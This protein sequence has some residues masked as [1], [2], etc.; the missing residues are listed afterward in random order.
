MT[1]SQ[2]HPADAAGSNPQPSDQAD[3][4]DANPVDLASVLAGLTRILA[5]PD[6]RLSQTRDRLLELGCDRL[7]FHAGAIAKVS[8]STC[9]IRA[10]WPTPS[11]PSAPADTPTRL[12]Q[13][14]A[15]SQ[16]FCQRTIDAGQTTAIQNAADTEDKTHPA[17]QELGIAAYLGTPITINGRVW[18]TLSFTRQAPLSRAISPNDH[19]VIELIAATLGAEMDRDYLQA[20]Y[21]TALEEADLA[22]RETQIVLD[23]L[24]AMVWR[25]DKTNTIFQTNK[26]AAYAVGA[27]P[28]QMIGRPIT[29]FYPEHAEASH[30]EDLEVIRSG[31]PLL[32][33]IESWADDTG[34]TRFVQ[35]DRIP[36]RNPT[37]GAIDGILVVSND[38]T[39]LKRAEDELRSMNVRFQAFTRNSP[40]I[41]WA[42]DREGRYVF[43]N[44]AFAEMMQVE[45]EDCVGK[46]PTDVLEPRTAKAFEKIMNRSAVLEP[47][48]AD[49][50]SSD[51]TALEQDSQTIHADLP[52]DHRVVPLMV[53]RFTYT[54]AQGRVFFGGT[55]MDLTDV[56]AAQRELATRNK[57]LKALL[58]VISHDL[59]EPLRAIR[60]F[61]GLVVER[62]AAQLGESSQD[63]L[64]RVV[65]GAERLDQL[66]SDVLTLS[67]AQRAE[68]AEGK[69]SS[70]KIVREVLGDL[71][72]SIDRSSATIS[73]GEDLP[74]LEVDA[75]WLRQAI[76]NMVT[77][78][79]KFTRDDQP[80]RLT[81]SAYRCE[82][83]QQASDD[84]ADHAASQP[85][86][87]MSQRLRVGL[88]FD[89]AGPGVESHQ[90]ERIFGLF[91]RGVSREVPGT[92]AGLAIVAQ[93]A[94]RFGGRVWVTDSPQG[95]ARFVLAFG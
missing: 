33:K 56:A 14:L 50:S 26:A 23:R 29:E 86:V 55:A 7:G 61:S 70:G 76:H 13:S 66:L 92:G 80:P 17:Y 8:G 42:V 89:D 1:D 85:E 4:S 35:T 25:K 93:V 16:T 69:V 27:T 51:G 44:A 54:D 32:G 45:A 68:P 90:R 34:D 63:M 53:T 58:Y 19:R 67:R 81:I 75:F 6:R 94:E 49:P 28:E 22:R 21:D 91:Q 43:I 74:D 40:A 71:Q 65:R 39:H 46:R 60:N 20:K 72:A 24:P 11:K 57:D 84:Q 12:G 48:T 18:G 9:D 15:L 82:L 62:E 95:G 38:I 78:A 41:E 64:R 3:A 36:T 88:V 2:A 83:D 73:V 31:K 37:T 77:N 59:R 5:D 47:S 52:V 87:L 79:I 30:R 10:A